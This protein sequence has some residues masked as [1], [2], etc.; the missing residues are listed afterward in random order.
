MPSQISR[1]LTLIMAAAAGLSVANI[2]YNQPMLGLIVRDFGDS[3]HVRLVPAAT[4][5]GYALGLLLL[6]PMGDAFDRRRLILT[7]NI[8]LVIAL[9]VAAAAPSAAV[10]LVA[11]VVIGALS[12]IAQQ[13]VPLA[14]DLAPADRRG[15]VVGTVMSGLLTGILLARTISG[16]I[17]AWFDWRAMFWA[18]TLIAA[19]MAVMLAITLPR[20]PPAQR[21]AYASLLLS[22]GELTRSQPRLRRA[23]MTQGAQ[24]AC[25]SIFWTT[26]ALLLQE[27]PFLLGSAVAGLFGIV[28]LTGVIVAPMAG[29]QSDKRGPQG[30]IGFGLLLVLAAFIVFAVVPGLAGLTVGVILLDTG[31]TMSM[32]ANQSVIFSLVPAARNRINTI[33]MTGMFLAGAAGSAASGAAWSNFGWPGVTG[34]GLAVSLA[35]LAFHLT[36]RKK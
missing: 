3:G 14:A 32:I 11:S 27:P 7:Q 23:M 22:L 20:H 21:H 30:I 19:L 25:F 6:V 36:R 24:F 12:T 2:Y 29:R 8:I 26:L 18:G 4:Q 15:Q 35:G 1:R 17:G 13:I 9:A 33:Y 10:L 5:L 34:L 16:S 31:V 28:G